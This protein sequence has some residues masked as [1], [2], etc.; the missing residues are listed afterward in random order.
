MPVPIPPGNRLELMD[1]FDPRQEMGRVPR[2]YPFPFMGVGDWF[3]ID[4][5]VAA[6]LR[7]AIRN[8]KLTHADAASWHFRVCACPDA[9]EGAHACIRVA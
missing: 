3:A 9:G 4:R 1:P 5:S 7:F 6:S 2:K 8:F